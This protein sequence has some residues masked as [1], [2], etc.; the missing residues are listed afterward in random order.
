MESDDEYYSEGESYD[1]EEENIDNINNTTVLDTL[2][3]IDLKETQVQEIEPS[4]TNIPITNPKL[5]TIDSP[6]YIRYKSTI[7]G[8]P[9]Y[10]NSR[11]KLSS[12]IL[13]NERVFKFCNNIKEYG[14]NLEIIKQHYKN[15]AEA[16][17]TEDNP[18]IYNEFIVVEY[19]K[20]QTDVYK[21][22]CE[23]I[24]GHHRMRALLD[25][26]DKKP[27]FNIIIRVSVIQSDYPDSIETKSI[28][29][30]FNIT[31]PFIVD[32][33]IMEITELII[34]EL[35]THFKCNYT[36][37][38]LIKDNK[39]VQRPSIKQSVI[40][41]CIQKRLNELKTLY[42]INRNDID[43]DLIIQNFIKY[44]NEISKEVKEDKNY[45]K[46]DKTITDNLIEKASKVD[47]FLGLV[48]TDMLVKTCIGEEY[49]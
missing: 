41:D 13:E 10:T 35:K 49:D 4:I 15:I 26:F 46:T 36:K 17:L 29:R 31:K 44:N 43:I 1:L 39:Q 2:T 19:T 5:Y 16:L 47:C 12:F 18:I 7:L 6:K 9:I 3:N 28:F 45:L 21:S 27:K 33:D 40:N 11:N 38:D 42:H 34:T 25:I 37:F 32:F 20:L 22:L 23:I 24:D 8:T 48:K 30:K 14:S